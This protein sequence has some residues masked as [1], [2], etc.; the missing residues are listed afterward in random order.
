MI[1]APDKLNS[2]VVDSH[3][4]YGDGVPLSAYQ[5]SLPGYVRMIP[6]NAYA[7]KIYT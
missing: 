6:S 4:A 2:S 3:A 7:H 1:Y 5:P